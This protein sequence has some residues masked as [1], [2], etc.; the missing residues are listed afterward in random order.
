M[1]RRLAVIAACALVPALAATSGAT[2][3]PDRTFRISTA[4]DLSQLSGDS[5]DTSLSANGQIIGFS[6]TASGFM[7]GDAN[8]SAEHRM[9][10]EA[11]ASGTS[12][13]LGTRRKGDNP[14]SC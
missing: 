4:P 12:T 1:S 3:L 5:G 2:S 9:R 8:G 7:P 14:E 10:W 6:S 13:L 11:P